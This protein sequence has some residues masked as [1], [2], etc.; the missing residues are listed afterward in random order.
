MVSK[1]TTPSISAFVSGE[2][3]KNKAIRV[4]WKNMSESLESFLSFS[5]SLWRKINLQ[6]YS[7]QKDGEKKA[8]EETLTDGLWHKVERKTSN[9][10][11]QFFGPCMKTVRQSE[12]FPKRHTIHR[13]WRATCDVQTHLWK[14][15]LM[16]MIMW[17]STG[18][19][20]RPLGALQD[21]QV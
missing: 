15:A 6:P 1:S 7:K 5:L 18:C 19:A 9:F 11:P 13:W 16:T 21:T 3:A 4:E 17:S 20:A 12:S 8:L 14:A 10:F 2:A